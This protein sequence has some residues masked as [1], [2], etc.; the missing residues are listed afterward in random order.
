MRASQ[1]R[2]S[3]WPGGG[4]KPLPDDIDPSLRL[5]HAWR[6]QESEK[7]RMMNAELLI[8]LG[9]QNDGGNDLGDLIALINDLGH[10]FSGLKVGVTYQ[11]EP[12]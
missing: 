9:G 4:K 7:E 12:V 5:H 1:H 6:A 8:T 2:A 3:G 11:A 10:S